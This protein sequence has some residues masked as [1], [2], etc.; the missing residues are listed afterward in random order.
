MGVA[1]S[2]RVSC[3]NDSSSIQTLSDPN[4]SDSNL[5]DSNPSDPKLEAVGR[6][7]AAY[8]RGDVEA[9]L[10]E[11]AD[12]VDWA[13]EA[14]SRSVPWYGEFRGKAEVPKFFAAIGSNVD[15]TVFPVVSSQSLAGV[16]AWFTWLPNLSRAGNVSS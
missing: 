3:M 1:A 15:V 6:L 4:F 13:A 2:V 12:D 14:S 16:N 8:G 11:V 10:A 9:V 5:S 7:Y